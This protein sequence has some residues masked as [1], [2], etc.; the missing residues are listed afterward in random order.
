MISTRCESKAYLR[1]PLRKSFDIFPRE[2]YVTKFVI[3]YNHELLSPSEV[4]F[5]PTNQVITKEDK[6]RILL[7]KNSGLSVRQIIRVM[8]LEKGVKHGDLPFFKKIG[9]AHV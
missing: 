1:I 4:R 9:R 7:L 2:W 8:E 3:D 6:D 5:L